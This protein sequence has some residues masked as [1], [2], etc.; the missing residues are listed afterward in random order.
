M[1][2]EQRQELEKNGLKLLRSQFNRK[3]YWNIVVQTPKGGWQVYNAEKFE[4][5]CQCETAIKKLT[6]SD[7]TL[8]M[9]HDLPF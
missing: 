7:S 9:D 6:E 3:G 8:V 1:K 4:N 5:N 2:K